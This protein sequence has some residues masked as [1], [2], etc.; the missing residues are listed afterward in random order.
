M[1]KTLLT[2]LSL[3]VFTLSFSQEIDRKSTHQ[4]HSEEFGYTKILKSSYNPNGTDIIPLQTKKST[5]LSK[6]IFGFLP[7][8]EYSSG[9]HDNL[10]YDLLT[11]IAAFDFKASASGTITNP[12]GWPWTNVINAAHT[13]GVKVIMAVTNFN[14]SQIHTLLTNSTSK[15]ALFTAIKNTIT[16]YQLDGV[17]ID[18]EGLDSADRGS[19]INTFMADLTSYIHSNLPGKEVSFDA[20]A[21]NWSGWELNDLAEAV[22]Q[23]IVM[24]YDYNGGVHILL[25]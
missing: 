23:L 17:N 20:P 2:S 8:W 5:N 24:A 16:T 1:K 18:F 9:A 7:Y 3:L 15:T 4:Q 12:S 25:R 21:V 6:I 14:S 11:H 10:Q 19:L 22:D 13:E